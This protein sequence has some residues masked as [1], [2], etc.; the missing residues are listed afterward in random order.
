MEGVKR[1]R[2]QQRGGGPN[3][4]IGLVFFGTFQADTSALAPTKRGGLVPV[5][6]RTRG[7]ERRDSHD[8]YAKFVQE[9]DVALFVPEGG[10]VNEESRS[11]LHII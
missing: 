10:I 6:C 5:I 9:K 7:V 2:S 8:L 11:G 3:L 4:F 1:L